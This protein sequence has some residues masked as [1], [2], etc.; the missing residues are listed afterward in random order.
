MVR[1]AIARLGQVTERRPAAPLGPEVRAKE[2]AV[3]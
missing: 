3:E 2:I 1:E